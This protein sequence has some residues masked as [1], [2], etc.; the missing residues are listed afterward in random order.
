MRILR[1]C[2]IPYLLAMTLWLWGCTHVEHPRVQLPS[3]ETRAS[4][5]TVG[6]VSPCTEFKGDFGAPTSGKGAGAAKGAGMG[7]AV[8]FLAPAAGAA[9]GNNPSQAVLGAALGVVLFPVFAIGGT[10]YGVAAAWPKET[11]K[12]AEDSIGDV[13][14]TVDIQ[15]EMRDGVFKVAS[16]MTSCNVVPII[17]SFAESP[18]PAGEY[19]S[20]RDL[21]ASGL[22]TAL[23]V[24]V[25]GFRFSGT[26]L[27]I[28]PPLSVNL[29]V[30][31]RL[32][33]CSDG[34]ELYANTFT[35][36]G[37]L[38]TYLEWAGDEAKPFR[39]E[40]SRACELLSHQI[41]KEALL[42]V[43]R[44]SAENRADVKGRQR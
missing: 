30:K 11:I 6:V 14:K 1:S 39:E 7:A 41:V 33:R 27:A 16:E 37:Q 20:Y 40:I 12:E 29:E 9:G 26:G 10:I 43:P 44:R 8:G 28:D 4:F 31:A 3:K 18:P 42:G 19:V 38:K 35:Y 5:G 34:K 23:V 21:K 22:D 15:Q 25:T 24:E 2:L 17:A 32:V 36:S 13:L